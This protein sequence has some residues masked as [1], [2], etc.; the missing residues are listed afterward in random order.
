MAP[1]AT[2]TVGTVVDNDDGTFDYTP[3]P[4]FVGDDTFTYTQLADA[5]EDEP[6]NDNPA[7]ATPITFP[8]DKVGSYEGTDVDDFHLF[9]ATAGQTIVIDLDWDD[10]SVDLDILVTDEGV[11]AFVCFDGAT[12]AAPEVS[13]CAI[14]A[15][16]DYQLWINNY[17]G[18]FHPTS[19]RLQA[20]VQ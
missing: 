9:S 1:L 10:H 19:Y 2:G 13:T 11:T 4:G 20:E 6:A 16:G 14:P 8:L 18:P 5:A 15:D 17:S 7:T 3:A 12:G